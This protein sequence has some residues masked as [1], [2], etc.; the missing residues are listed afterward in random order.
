M[1]SPYN[2]RGASIHGLRYLVDTVIEYYRGS[3]DIREFTI[4]NAHSDPVSVLIAVILSQNTNDLNSTRAYRTLVER[5]GYPLRPEVLL[6]IG[7]NDLADMIR[8]SGM[9]Y[10]KAKTIL[11][12]VRSITS[13]EL[14]ELDPE[15]LRKRLLKIPGIGYKT[16]D[17]FL[18]MFRRYPVFPIDTHIR[19]ILIRYGAVSPRDSYETMRKRVEKDLPKDPDY[20]LR[21]HLSLIKHGRTICRARVFK[22]GE[23]PVVKYCAK[24]EVVS[25]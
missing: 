8:I 24:V 25:R 9:Q 2:A 1:D 21:A 3:L 13:K 17:V 16:A 4:F 18:L 5:V 7:L 23:C 6:S 22:C 15:E 14:A 11:N 10:V 19:R 20:L 12:L